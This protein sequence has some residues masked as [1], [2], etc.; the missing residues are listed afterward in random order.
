M[1]ILSLAL[2][3]VTVAA[4]TI[5]VNSRKYSCH[6]QGFLVQTYLTFPFRSAIL[7]EAL[8]TMFQEHSFRCH[9]AFFDA[10]RYH[11][12]GSRRVLFTSPMRRSKERIV[13]LVKNDQGSNKDR[14]T[15][16]SQRR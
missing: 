14:I 10:L 4:G 1:A 15:T 11:V 8:D 16:L 3:T 13:G 7:A 12:R 6:T 2:H 9:R 5:E